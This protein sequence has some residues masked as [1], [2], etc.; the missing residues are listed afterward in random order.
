[1]LALLA[2][3]RWRHDRAGRAAAHDDVVVHGCVSSRFV[4]Q[5]LTR[6]A[7]WRNPRYFAAQRLRCLDVHVGPA[8]REEALS[9][10]RTLLALALVTAAGAAGAQTVDHAAGR[11]RHRDPAVSGRRRRDRPR[12]TAPPAVNTPAVPS[13]SVGAGGA[14]VTTP[15]VERRRRAGAVGRIGWRHHAFGVNPPGASTPGI[16]VADRDGAQPGQRCR[17]C[18]TPRARPARSRR[19]RATATRTCRA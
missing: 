19:S 8:M 4:G 3:S 7:M 16:A 9:M 13:R 14:T 5:T 6:W 10:K 1:M 18:P 15:P 17:R 2:D 12:P 11:R